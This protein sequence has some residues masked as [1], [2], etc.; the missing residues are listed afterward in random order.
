MQLLHFQ[1]LFKYEI[2]YFIRKC[3]SIKIFMII[4]DPCIMYT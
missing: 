3:I 4:Y 2:K 1:M